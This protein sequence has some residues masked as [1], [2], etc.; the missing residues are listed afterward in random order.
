MGSATADLLAEQM[1][2]GALQ[3]ALSPS[4]VLGLVSDSANKLRISLSSD[5]PSLHTPSSRRAEDRHRYG[6]WQVRRRNA[7]CGAGAAFR[8]SPT[9]Q[10]SLFMTPLPWTSACA[11]RKLPL[12]FR[13]K[14][15]GIFTTGTCSRPCCIIYAL[16]KTG[17]LVNKMLSTS[18]QWVR[19]LRT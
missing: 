13:P 18:R 14:S 2:A 15:C 11:G 10:R 4:S 3:S 12:C 5:A 7:T 19:P 6:N 9:E 16:C 1:G 17:G 8:T